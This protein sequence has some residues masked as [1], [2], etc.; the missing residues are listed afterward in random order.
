MGSATEET[1]RRAFEWLQ[2]ELFLRA[3]Q[4]GGREFEGASD[5]KTALRHWKVDPDLASIRDK[6][7]ELP[8]AEREQ[9]RAFWVDVDL[10]L[11]RTA[12]AK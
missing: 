5:A 11:A 12:V 10:L 9:W 2:G 6:I 3:A 7:D 4:V 8:G 1:R